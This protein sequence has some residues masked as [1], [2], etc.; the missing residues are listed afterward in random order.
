M[1]VRIRLA[2][3]GS[4]KQPFYRIV[5]SDSRSAR[6]GK[7]IEKIGIYDPKREPSIMEVDKERA[8]GWINKGA[9]PTNAVK[10]I[11]E[12]VNLKS[13]DNK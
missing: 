3:L 8:M 4:K 7:F 2:R 5:V 12:K 1:S 9:K 11:F 10:K 13:S 6:D